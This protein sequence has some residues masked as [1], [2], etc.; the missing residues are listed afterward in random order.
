MGYAMANEF[1][2][3]GDS[4]VI[5]GRDK[6]RVSDAVSSLQEQH[7]NSSISGT[8]CDV[9]KATDMQGLAEFA[10]QQLGTVDYWINNAGQVTA[11]RILAGR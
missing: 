7:S 6:G 8:Q 1:L 11:K 4:V 9:S 2:A 5:C 3:A 10:L